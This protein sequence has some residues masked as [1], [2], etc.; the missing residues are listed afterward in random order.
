MISN[1]NLER[2][3]SIFLVD[4]HVTPT[5]QVK[6]AVFWDVAPHGSCKSWRFGGTYH[7]HHQGG[8]SELETT[9]AVI[10]YVPPK[11]LLL[12]G[13]Q[14]VV[15]SQK[16]AFSFTDV[17]CHV[18]SIPMHL[19]LWTGICV[20]SNKQTPWPLVRE[21]TIPTER[22][23]LVDEILCQLLWIKGCRVDMCTVTRLMSG[24]ASNLRRVRVVTSMS[25]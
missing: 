9:L 17:L 25:L 14:G 2:M 23:P 3:S 24:N 12:H 6:N 19:F 11:R 4:V 7:L 21:R 5:F 16:T 8:I 15:T 1:W 13:P 18:A 22:P 20:P 10:N